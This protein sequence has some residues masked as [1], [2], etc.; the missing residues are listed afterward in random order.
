MQIAE[1]SV[2]SIEYTLKDDSGNVLDTSEGGDALSYLHGAGNIIPGLENALAGKNAGEEL[3]VTVA[4][5]QAYGQRNEQL[6]QVV[7]RELF[8]SIDDIAVGMQFQGQSANEQPMII[9]ITAIEGD[10]VT[11]DGNHPLA[12]VNLNF[13]IKILEVRDATA[14]ELEHGHIH[15]PDGHDHH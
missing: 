5:E 11:I 3:S 15:G 9:T 13:D 7:S 8:K 12:G 6:I 2:V 10:N 4:P 1:N 14:E